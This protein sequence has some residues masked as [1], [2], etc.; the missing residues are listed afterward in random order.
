M[1]S[2]V[3]GQG[4]NNGI[5]RGVP[6]GSIQQLFSAKI[7]DL[8]EVLKSTR[9]YYTEAQNLPFRVSEHLRNIGQEMLP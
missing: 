6:A 8:K 4:T 7:H 9:E 5:G 1:T 2:D 3:T